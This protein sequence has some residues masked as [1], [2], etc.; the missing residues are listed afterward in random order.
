MAF[1]RHTPLPPPGHRPA[2]PPPH[3][4]NHH[5]KSHPQGLSTK[6]PD[7][8]RHPAHPT[9]LLRHPPPRTRH[10]HPNHPRTPRPRKRQHHHDLHPRTQPRPP[11]RHQPPGS[12]R[13]HLTLQPSTLSAIQT[14]RRGTPCPFPPK[15]TSHSPPGG[16]FDFFPPT[17]SSRK[18]IPLGLYRPV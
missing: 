4:R 11:G 17:L 6:W 8:A 7:Q 3:P 5:P 16:P 13:P 14:R 18:P 15:T 2:P 12:P 9:T 1:P 10:R